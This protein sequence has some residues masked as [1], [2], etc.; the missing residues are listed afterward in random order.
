MTLANLSRRELLDA[1]AVPHRALRETELTLKRRLFRLEDAAVK[2][3]ADAY[4][5]FYRMLRETAANEAE[6]RGLTAIAPD[7]RGLAWRDAVLAQARAQAGPLMLAVATAAMRAGVSAY[8]LGFYGKLWQLDV[9]TRKDVRIPK[10]PPARDAVLKQIATPQLKEDVY[11]DLIQQ[12]LGK[13]WRELYAADMEQLTAEIRRALGAGMNEGEGMAA[14]MRR[15]RGAIGVQTDRRKGFRANFNRVQAIT[16]TVVQ[17]AAN[18]GAVEVYRRNSD[19]LSGYTWITAND[20][21]R[22]ADCA[23]MDGKNFK[24]DDTM[25]P[26]LHPQCRCGV[27]PLIAEDWKTRE[28]E[29]PRETFNAWVNSTGVARLFGDMLGVG[30]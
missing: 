9:A 28:D 16:R 19:V 15:V 6:R 30:P 22:C 23:A 13:E 8:Y 12:L 4:T 7:P 11:D 26:P 1:D 18:N 21:R 17:T 5:G 2:A 25:R 20:E 24:L 3:Q 14:I 29:R 27:V 10:E